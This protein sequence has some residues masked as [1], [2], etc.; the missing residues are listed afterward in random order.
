M[1]E[2]VLRTE[3][4]TEGR[5]SEEPTTARKARFWARDE[6]IGRRGSRSLVP[7]VQLDPRTVSFGS[8]I[9]EITSSG[10]IH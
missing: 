8:R 9:W 6:G 3:E 5:G 2:E 10:S 7:L 4:W 1:E